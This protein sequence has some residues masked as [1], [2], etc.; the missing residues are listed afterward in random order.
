MDQPLASRDQT[1]IHIHCASGF[2]GRGPET[3]RYS[4]NGYKSCP[5]HEL[6]RQGTACS[7]NNDWRQVTGKSRA[8]QEPS[9]RCAPASN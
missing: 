1:F 7:A 8:A 6:S 4:G 9:S 2:W 3:P 5:Q